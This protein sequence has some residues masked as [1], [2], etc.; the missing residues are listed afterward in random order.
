MNFPGKVEDYDRFLTAVNFEGLEYAVLHYDNW[1]EFEFTDTK[2]YELIKNYQ[3][4][5]NQLEQF[6]GR[7]E[8]QEFLGRI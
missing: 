4:A 2:L 6:I 5:A 8:E 1:D 3:K 7:L